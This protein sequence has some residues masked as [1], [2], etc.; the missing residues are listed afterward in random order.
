[1]INL[2]MHA[3]GSCVNGRTP[4]IAT[5]LT[6]GRALTSDVVRSIHLRQQC[7][8]VVM[9]TAASVAAAAAAAAAVCKLINGRCPLRT[10]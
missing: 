5:S 4:T 1:V 2:D 9:A 10:R 6:S 7:C 8:R 3:I